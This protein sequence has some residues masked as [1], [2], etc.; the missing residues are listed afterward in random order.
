MEFNIKKSVGY[1]VGSTNN[2]LKKTFLDT[3]AR[4]EQDMTTEQFI[5][6][7][8]IH[9]HTSLSQTEIAGYTGRDKTTTT[10]A[11][12]VLT[13]KNY[14]LRSK[15]PNDRRVFK[16]HLTEEGVAAL[17]KMIPAINTLSETL[18]EGITT[19][20]MEQLMHILTKIQINANNYLKGE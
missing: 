12:D 8:V 4:Y 15:D 10:R 1:M 2:I 3:A 6:M 5:I 19:E 13:K 20:E 11:I 14:A 16:V 7:N 17:L 9:K 18:A